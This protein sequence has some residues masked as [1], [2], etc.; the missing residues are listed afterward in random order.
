MERATELKWVVHPWT[1]R[2][3]E[4]FFA[5]TTSR[6]RQRKLHQNEEGSRSRSGLSPF[7]T[8]LDE[9]L[10]LRCTVGVHGVFSESVDVAVRAMGTPCPDKHASNNNNNN[11]AG[12]SATKSLF[13]TNEV[14]LGPV[15]LFSFFSGILVALLVFKHFSGSAQASAASPWQAQRRQAP[16]RLGRRSSNLGP[17]S[18]VP[19]EAD[20]YD[21]DNDNACDDDADGDAGVA[22]GGREASD[23]EIL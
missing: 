1:E 12:A 16:R 22:I 19:T 8:V 10:F 2:P 14:P 5:T 20:E 11:N 9:M 7:A 4:E 21:R 3:E 13:D 15:V 6:K 17:H 18:A 23:R